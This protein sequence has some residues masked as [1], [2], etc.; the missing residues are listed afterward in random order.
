M[1]WA[2]LRDVQMAT[3]IEFAKWL[4]D[5]HLFVRCSSGR[6]TR[7]LGAPAKNAIHIRGRIYH[8]P[9]ARTYLEKS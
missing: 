6:W 2:T 8:M 3:K 7:V 1:T 5:G 4:A 9:D